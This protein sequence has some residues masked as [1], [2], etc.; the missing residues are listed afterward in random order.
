MQQ[1][2]GLPPRLRSP[3]RELLEHR[4]LPAF[5][6]DDAVRRVLFAGCA[7]YTQHYP[8]LLP[9]AEHWTLDADPRCRRYGVR[10]HITA[11]LQNLRAQETG[12]PFD[13]IVC[14][15]V[16]GWG[17]DAPDDAER[18]MRACHDTLRAGGYLLL[19]WNDVFPRNRVRPEQIAALSSFQ[20]VGYCGLPESIRVRSA[21]RHVFD[22]Y[23]RP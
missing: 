3:D 15:G 22:L 18:A 8:Q 14:N 6:R 5:G 21:G 2:C 9:A 10:Q 23:R 20:R 1:V 19:G 12:G 16:L 17:L 11:P 7:P 4:I 13:L